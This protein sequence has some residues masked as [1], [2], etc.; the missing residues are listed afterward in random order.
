[1][2]CKYQTCASFYAEHILNLRGYDVLSWLLGPSHVFSWQL[3]DLLAQLIILLTTYFQERLS[4]QEILCI[5][6]GNCYGLD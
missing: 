5:G 3:T 2:W 4:E 1:M 6:L